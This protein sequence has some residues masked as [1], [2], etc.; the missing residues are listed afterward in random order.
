MNADTWFVILEPLEPLYS[1]DQDERPSINSMS[2][3]SS[4]DRSKKRRW[5]NLLRAPRVLVSPKD[6]T[7]SKHDTS[8]SKFA[9]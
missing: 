3:D 8:R 7:T 5:Q 6:K 9:G 2:E 1:T 4:E